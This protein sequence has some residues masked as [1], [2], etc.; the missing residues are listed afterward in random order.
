[1]TLD[2]LLGRLSLRPGAAPAIVCAR[3]MVGAAMMKRLTEGRRATLLPDLLATVFT[4]CA[5]AQRATARRA[6]RAAFG[7][8][9][10]PADAARDAQMLALVTAREHLQRLAL[11]LPA[12]V[13]AEGAP[14]D[15]A[16]IR[17]APV[18]SL[19][20]RLASG[21]DVLQPVAA[22]LP[23]WLER[24]LFGMP[25]ADWLRAWQAGRGAWL[26]EWSR[27]RAH[28][29]ARWLRGVRDEALALPLPCRALGLAGQGEAGWRALGR[30]LAAD[31]Q[32]AERPHWQAA[33]AET[34]PWTRQGRPDPVASPWDR[35]G[36]RLADLAHV[37]LHACERPLA[38]GALTLAPGEGLAWSEMSRGLLVH[39][40]RLEE[41][42][43]AVDVARAEL[44]R[45]IAPTEWN[46][47]PEGALA[48][49]VARATPR[50]ARLAAATL[51]PC[52]SFDVEPEAQD[53]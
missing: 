6:V 9:D 5:E 15:P 27:S 11:D 43:R 3:P 14:A 45:V 52:M 18:M 41:G 17:D 31:P 16:W 44:Y 26:D 42:P 10:T 35:H 25:P 2:G 21:G 47:H 46:F 51:D 34:G 36:A 23:G 1:M 38:C 39:W 4:L 24:R 7:L 28:P 20:Q 12:L 37:A 32:L 30:E 53:A 19:P 13:P 8:A 49:A 48:A 50:Q 33:P 40:V 22:A 29:F